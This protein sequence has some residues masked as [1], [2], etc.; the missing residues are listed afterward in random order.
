MI[1]TSFLE[2]EKKVLDWHKQKK[3]WHFHLLTPDCIFNQ[4]N[5]QN[6]FVVENISDQIVFIIYSS[7]RNMLLGKKLLSLLHGSKILDRNDQGI[8][9]SNRS[10]ENILKKITIMNQKDIVWH[11]HM[12]FPECV[13]N[14]HKG[15]WNITFEDQ[16]ADKKI[17]ALYD[18]EPIDDLKRIE[19]FYYEQKE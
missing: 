2:I 14:S 8:K 13:F 7:K 5:G 10:F 3:R 19:I 18:K 4:K 16:E 1:K 17:E 11:H 12:F 9:S 6:A 15:E